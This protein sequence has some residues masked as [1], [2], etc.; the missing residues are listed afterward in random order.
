[1][2]LGEGETKLEE[3]MDILGAHVARDENDFATRMKL[4][5]FARARQRKE[6]EL[7]LAEHVREIVPLPNLKWSREDC[8]G[9]HE[10]I[11]QLRLER[12]D[13]APAEL[14]ARCAAEVAIMSLG[15]AGEKPLEPARRAELLA[16]HAET[17]RLL[18][19]SDESASRAREAIRLD[20][21]NVEAAET[22]RNLGS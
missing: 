20:P 17:L 22:L 21:E 11:S 1:M 7:D 8:A 15:S 10:R 16:A 3:A 12:K 2:L 4:I 5:D 6:V 19:R 18:G 13:H 9:I 14:A